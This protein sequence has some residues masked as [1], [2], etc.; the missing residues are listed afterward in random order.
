MTTSTMMKPA[1]DSASFD[2]CNNAE[3]RVNADKTEYIVAGYL[4][5]INS[6]NAKLRFAYGG[7]AHRD[8][9]HWTVSQIL[10]GD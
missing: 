1:P 10:T 8:G 9:E 3:I 5:A 7:R 4:S 2:S 6:F